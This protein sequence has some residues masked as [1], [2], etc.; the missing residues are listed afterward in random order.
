[1][2]SSKELYIDW[3]KENYQPQ[4]LDANEVTQ[5]IPSSEDGEGGLML[6]QRDRA[7]LYISKGYNLALNGGTG[8]GKST[9]LK[10]IAALTAMPYYKENCYPKMTAEDAMMKPTLMNGVALVH[11]GEL[12][13]AVIHNGFIH[14]EEVANVNP[15]N[16]VQFH[17]IFDKGIV[18]MSTHFGGVTYHLKDHEN[19]RVVLAGNFDYQQPD[20]N[21]ATTQRFIWMK[22][23]Y[24]SDNQ[25]HDLLVKKETSKHRMTDQPDVMEG[26]MKKFNRIYVEENEIE[27]GTYDTLGKLII[28]IKND[29]YRI[30]EVPKDVNPNMLMRLMDCYSPALQTKDFCKIAEETVLY[31]LA[32][33]QIYGG[34]PV[35]EKMKD[36]VE[37]Q[38]KSYSALFSEK[39]E[40]AKNY[41][42]MGSFASKMKKKD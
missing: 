37:K 42:F 21:P 25:L 16:I 6:D 33:R 22:I 38:V 28:G 18:S 20:F 24:L 41:D 4:M 2:A 3:V 8:S 30:K 40:K 26:V 19:F 7:L 31:P 5:F 17:E 29:I 9:L 36:V 13:K 23:P 14:L 32:A 34:R 10:N 15:D 27:K 12:T 35:L 11:P 1:M 39:H